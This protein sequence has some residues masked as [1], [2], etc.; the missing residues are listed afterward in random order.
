MDFRSSSIKTDDVKDLPVNPAFKDMPDSLKDVDRYDEV[1]EKI[2]KVMH[3]DHTHRKVIAF[4]KC[5]QCAKKMERRRRVL[6]DLGFK[7]YQ[8]YL[9]WRKV[10][11]LLK[12]S[13]N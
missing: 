13:Q 5:K 10:M 9:S 8:Q 11:Q 12:N 1:V 6:K 2:A 7:D 4:T 3:S